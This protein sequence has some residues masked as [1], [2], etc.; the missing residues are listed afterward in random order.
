M[1]TGAPACLVSLTDLVPRPRL[2]LDFD[3]LCPLSQW[4]RLW[5]VRNDK[6][7]LLERICN[8]I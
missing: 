2:S 5:L 1:L 3:E 8:Q 4:G 6:V 7:L